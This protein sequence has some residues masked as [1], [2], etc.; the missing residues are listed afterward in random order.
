MAFIRINQK[1]LNA[2]EAR[3]LGNKIYS[4]AGQ[5]GDNLSCAAVYLSRD[6]NEGAAAGQTMAAIATLDQLIVD[7]QALRDKLLA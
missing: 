1:V 2:R 6:T 5:V 3:D 4:L 7:A